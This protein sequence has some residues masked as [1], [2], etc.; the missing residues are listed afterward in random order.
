MEDASKYNK[1]PE[2]R[3]QR[4]ELHL[5]HIYFRKY[6]I[7]SVVLWQAYQHQKLSASS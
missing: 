4:F 7:F 6:N 2:T 5:I 1:A 3:G